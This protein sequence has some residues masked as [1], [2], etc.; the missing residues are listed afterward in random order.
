MIYVRLES[1]VRNEPLPADG[2]FAAPLK[3]HHHELETLITRGVARRKTW[4]A[5]L[6]LLVVFGLAAGLR[7]V[8]VRR[9]QVGDRQANL[10]DQA[11]ISLGSD[12]LGLDEDTLS[13]LDIARALRRVDEGA[14]EDLVDD[15]NTVDLV[16]EDVGENVIARRVEQYLDNLLGRLGLNFLVD[17]MEHRQ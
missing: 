2:Y 16:A 17:N 3:G 15:S 9:L 8:R 5:E 6:V 13:G 1:K 7:D 14:G 11:V 4:H 12:D 10:F